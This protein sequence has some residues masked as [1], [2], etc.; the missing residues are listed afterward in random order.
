[1]TSIRVHGK[2]CL[3]EY[4][5]HSQNNSPPREDSNGHAAD[6][7]SRA[8]LRQAMPA[9]DASEGFAQPRASHTCRHVSGSPRGGGTV[10]G[11]GAQC[12]AVRPARS[13]RWHR[14]AAPTWRGPGARHSRSRSRT[15]QQRA[16]EARRRERRQCGPQRALPEPCAN[17][18]SGAGRAHRPALAPY[19][20][21]DRRE[22]PMRHA[23]LQAARGGSTHHPGRVAHGTF[24]RICATAHSKH[25]A[26]PE[27]RRIDWTRAAHFRNPML[28]I[29]AGE[30]A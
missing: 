13:C 21:P 14:S 26:R 28:L 9:S 1:M 22:W 29:P 3:L 20:R 19:R 12:P 17:G 23:H 8:K 10:P 4:Y 6:P 2:Q 16:T 11:A 25:D 27:Q 7:F 30:A 5:L 24:S 18:P 15:W